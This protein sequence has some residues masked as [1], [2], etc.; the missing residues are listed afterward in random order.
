M[1]SRRR[2]IADQCSQESCQVWEIPRMKS[3]IPAP[4]QGNESRLLPVS[5]D[6]M[7]AS[8]KLLAYPTQSQ[9]LSYLSSFYTAHPRKDRRLHERREKGSGRA[10]QILQQRFRDQI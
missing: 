2:N 10:N 4:S 5:F 6:A 7:T 9:P 8:V 1:R 3:A